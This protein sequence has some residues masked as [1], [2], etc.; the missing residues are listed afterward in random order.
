MPAAPAA[1]RRVYYCIANTVP[2]VLNKI[3]A[4]VKATAVPHGESLTMNDRSVSSP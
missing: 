2:K 1:K 4:T 3:A